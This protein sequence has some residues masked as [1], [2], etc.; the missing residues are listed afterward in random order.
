[1]SLRIIMGSSGQ[2]K[3]TH[4]L[5]EV[6]RLSKENKNQTYYIIVPEQFSLEMQQKLVESHPD[7]G[8]VNIDVLS[9]YRLAYRVF[10]ELRFS[11]RKIFWRIWAYH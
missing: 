5:E 8:Y 7:K 11:R 1:M 4:I 2:G 9:F 3:T 10:D 6:I